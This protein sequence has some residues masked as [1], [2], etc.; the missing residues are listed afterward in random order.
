MSLFNNTT[1]PKA[2][3]KKH[4]SFRSPDKRGPE[5]KSFLRV[6]NVVRVKPPVKGTYTVNGVV[7]SNFHDVKTEAIKQGFDIV[8]TCAITINLA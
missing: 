3:R 5:M 7:C 8:R 6:R 2:L 1:L 4:W